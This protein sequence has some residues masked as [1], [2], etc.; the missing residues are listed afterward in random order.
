MFESTIAGNRSTSDLVINNE[1][2]A[3]MKMFLQMLVMAIGLVVVGSWCIMVPYHTTYENRGYYY[4]PADEYYYPPAPAYY[5][6][7]ATTYYYPN[8]GYH[9]YQYRDVR[10]GNYYNNNCSP[11]Y[12]TPAPCVRGLL[13]R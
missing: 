3:V 12:V 10:Y 9:Q 4:P 11:L 6:E 8:R 2:M 7:P 5:G 13:P 1:R